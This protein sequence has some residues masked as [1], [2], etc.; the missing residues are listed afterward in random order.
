MT[1]RRTSATVTL[2]I[3]WSRPRTAMPLTTFVSPPTSRAAM[4]KACCDSAA[5]AAVP[6]SMTPSPD[7]LDLDVGVRHRLLERRAHAIEVTRHGNIKASDLLAV[8]IEEK[9][10]GLPDRD[11]DHVGAPRRTDDGVGDLGIGNQHVLDVGAAGRSRPICRSRA[12]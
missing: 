5:L 2:S 8:G 4:S 10:V 9:N 11:T 7:A 6:E 3:T 1:S 12:E